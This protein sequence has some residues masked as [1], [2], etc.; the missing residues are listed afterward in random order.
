MPDDAIVDMAVFKNTFDMCNTLTR[1][2]I[3]NAWP[4]RIQIG[5]AWPLIL[6]GAAHQCTEVVVRTIPEHDNAACKIGAIMASH[7]GWVTVVAGNDKEEYVKADS[8]VNF[9]KDVQRVSVPSAFEL[10]RAVCEFAPD[11][12]R[13]L[14]I[15]DN[16]SRAATLPKLSRTLSSNQSFSHRHVFLITVL[17]GKIDKVPMRLL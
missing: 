17:S 5:N 1:I 6:D 3:G 16:R 14:L 4:L 13:L 2:Q 8:H 12:Y 10:L 11:H 9:M 15:S 7:C